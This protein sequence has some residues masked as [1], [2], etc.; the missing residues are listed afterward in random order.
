MDRQTLRDWV[1][2]HNEAGLTGL[3][4]RHSGRTRPLLSPEQEAELA[5][6]VRQGP[7]LAE[8]G[9]VRWRRADLFCRRTLAARSKQDCDDPPDMVLSFEI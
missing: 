1:H 7:D 4:D 2:R 5:G 9:V 3:S 8:Y 6:W